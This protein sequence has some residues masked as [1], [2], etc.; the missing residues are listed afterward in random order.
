MLFFSKKTRS[1]HKSHGKKQRSIFPEGRLLIEAS[2][3]SPNPV[4]DDG[5]SYIKD[6]SHLCASLDWRVSEHEEHSLGFDINNR[7]HNTFLTTVFAGRV[8]VKLND[9]QE[10]RQFVVR[11]GNVEEINKCVLQFLSKPET[12]EIHFY[13]PT[14]QHDWDPT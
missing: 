9:H 14:S 3:F 12:T 4:R 11:N 10:T 13:S 1:E 5:I 2:G 6:G 8:G 7:G